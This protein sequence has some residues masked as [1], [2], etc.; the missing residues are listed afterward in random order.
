M[1][2]ILHSKPWIAE[3]DIEALAGLLRTGM[4]AQGERIRAFERALG[5]WLGREGLVSPARGERSP[6]G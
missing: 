3:D 4:L 6:L 2:L 5:D 1:S